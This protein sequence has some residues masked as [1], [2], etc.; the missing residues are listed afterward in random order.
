MKITGLVVKF[1]VLEMTVLVVVLHVVKM[2]DKVEQSKWKN[3]GF[4]GCGQCGEI[5]SFS[6]C[7]QSGENYDFSSFITCSKN[8]GLRGCCH[9]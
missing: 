6:G 5:D 3:D 1:N 4:T 7:T 8:G 9:Y 2:T